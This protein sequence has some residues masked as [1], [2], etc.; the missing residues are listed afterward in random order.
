M[1]FLVQLSM[2]A[3]TVAIARPVSRVGFRSHAIRGAE[4]VI[5][6]FLAYAAVAGTLAQ[7]SLA[8]TERIIAA[9]LVISLAYLLVIHFDAGHRILA[10]SV[11]RD[12]LPLAVLLFVYQEMGW[13]AHPLASHP[14]EVAWVR[15]DRMFLHGGVSSAVEAFGPLLPTFLEINY[16]LVYAIAPFC[17]AVLYLYRLRARSERLL[18]IVVVAVLLCYGQ[19]P[20]WPSEPP[21]ILFA[22]Q[23]LP[24][25]ET[26][27][28]RFNL[29][30]L[31]G[32]GIHTSVFPSAH[33]AAGFACA[34]G[35][36]KILPEHKW[37]SRL[38]F[39]MAFSIALAT[40]YGRYHYLAD[41]AAGFSMSIAALGIS[42]LAERFTMPFPRPETSVR[43]LS[44]GD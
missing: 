25:A 42:A 40:V 31:S 6:L 43:M 12:W 14:L 2:T 20:F 4:W 36:R 13:F 37:V 1:E 8:T 11:A 44:S 7:L 22:G 23:D 9:N 26:I 17:L 41:A 19:F 38:L 35:M 30:I 28:R 27:F 24:A 10:L 34:F 3:E 18:F 5:L 16:S 21:R 15:W 32:A 39:V 33:V 29:W